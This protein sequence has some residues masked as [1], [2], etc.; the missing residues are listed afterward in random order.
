MLESNNITFKGERLFNTPLLG[1][2]FEGNSSTPVLPHL[3]YLG[4][5]RN[6][7][8]A[9]GKDIFQPLH[10]SP[11]TTLNLQSCQLEFVHPDNFL[12]LPNL[13]QLDL[14]FNPKLFQVDRCASSSFV[15]PG[16]SCVPALRQGN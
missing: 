7:L 2:K 3:V 13:R 10:C 8:K 12:P 15:F 5:Q 4:L 11:V 1:L 14:Y 9:L 6:P 16:G